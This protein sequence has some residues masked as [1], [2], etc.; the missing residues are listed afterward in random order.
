MI[1]DPS[2]LAAEALTD[3]ANPTIVMGK[4]SI[5]FTDR[6]DVLNR[7]PL[8]ISSSGADVM[9]PAPGVNRPS[10]SAIIGS[11]DSHTAKYVATSR[12]QTGR[13]E[14]IND[15]QEMCQVLYLFVSYMWESQYNSSPQVILSQY[16]DY[17]VNVEKKAFRLSRLIFYRGE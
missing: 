15:M 16:K 10:Y 14:I 7:C 1:P 6:K 8:Y 2:S 13:R 5:H 12:A 9:H 11:V 4:C 3:P 17:Q